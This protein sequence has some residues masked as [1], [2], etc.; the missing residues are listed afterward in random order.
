MRIVFD[1]QLM[2]PGCVMLAAVMGGDTRAAMLFD[3]ERWL[4]SP[5]PNMAVFEISDEDLNW[6]AHRVNQPPAASRRRA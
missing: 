6:L 5:T 3:S 4:L 2:R 1:T